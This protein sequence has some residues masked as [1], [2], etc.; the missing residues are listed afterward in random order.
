VTA[1]RK[2]GKARKSKSGSGSE[3]SEASGEESETEAAAEKKTREATAADES[4][5]GNDASMAEFE[6][7]EQGGTTVEEIEDGESSHNLRSPKSQTPSAVMKANL[8]Q[9]RIEKMQQ[10]SGGVSGQ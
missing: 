4:Q 6:D 3:L 2:R 9:Q 5:E 7:A 8:R 1:G 10:A